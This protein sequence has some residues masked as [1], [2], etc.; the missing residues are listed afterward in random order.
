VT[1]DEAKNICMPLM[2]AET[3]DAVTEALR[4]EQF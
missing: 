2:Q 4:R 3:E 1:N